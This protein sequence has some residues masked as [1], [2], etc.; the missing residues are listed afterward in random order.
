MA[1]EAAMSLAL[2]PKRARLLSDRSVVGAGADLDAARAE[3]LG[4]L[5]GEIFGSMPWWTVRE[6]RVGD[7]RQASLRRVDTF[8]MR[9]DDLAQ[10]TEAKLLSQI[11]EI[12][13]EPELSVGARLV[14]LHLSARRSVSTHLPTRSKRGGLAVARV[15]C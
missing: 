1:A 2:M 13:A 3:D 12:H 7:E 11:A 4:G 9:K 5:A 15:C 8:E 14:L 6:S 10:T